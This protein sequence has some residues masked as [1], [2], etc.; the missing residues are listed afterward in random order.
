MDDRHNLTF[1]QA[2][3]AEPLPS[4][5]KPKELSAELLARLW[6]VVHRSLFQHGSPGEPW[7]SIFKREWIGRRHK[8]IDEFPHNYGMLFA[9]I[10]RIFSSNDYIEIF[11]WIQWIIRDRQ[12]PPSFVRGIETALI[13][14]RAGYRLVD[15]RSLMPIADE[16]DAAIVEGAFLAIEQSGAEGARSHLHNAIGALSDGNWA[17]SIRESILA[18]EAV[19]RKLSPKESTLSAALL[20]LEKNKSIHTAMK[21]GFNTLYG[22]TNDEKG[23]RHSLI[24]SPTANV[25]EVDAMFMLGTCSAAVSYLVQRGRGAGLL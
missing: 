10:K 24:D 14:C 15:N 8:F 20:K 6:D 11:D 22:W 18:V 1:A 17:D 2:E 12:V 3:G 13:E 16:M 4:Q 19:S 23:I 9:D 7:Q 25:D 21:N 5:L